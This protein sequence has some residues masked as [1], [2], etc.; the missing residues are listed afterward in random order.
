MSKNMKMMS[1]QS[2]V[3]YYEAAAESYDG[4]R[5][6]CKCRKLV[7]RLFKET[8]YD[9]VKNKNTILDA[10]TGTG[11]FAQYFAGKGKDVIAMDTSESML[12]KT[13]ERIQKDRTGRKIK[14]IYGDI[15][16]IPLGNKTVDAI[17]CIHVLVHFENI[18]KAIREFARVL[19]P[20]G[21]LVFELAN[22]RAAKSY[23]ILRRLITSEKYFS[24]PDHYHKYA[25]I[26]EIMRKNGFV[27]SKVKK[28]KKFPKVIMHLLICKCNL[29]F[30]ENFVRRMEACNFGTVSIIRGV[31]LT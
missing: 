27:I 1:K 8:I 20:G 6:G 11:R 31:K 28:I 23:N 30:L 19:K 10:G 9:L 7:D 15:E 3:S 29:S 16:E 17:T 22:S 5:F 26:R 2:C 12:A 21:V 14:P 13:R 4:E 25:D 24:F 18:E